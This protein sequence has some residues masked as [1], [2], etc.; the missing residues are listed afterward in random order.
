[1]DRQNGQIVGVAADDEF[2]VDDF[3]CRYPCVAAAGI[4]AARAR[5]SFCFNAAAR[6]RRSI[7]ACRCR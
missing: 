1:V 6:F 2:S 4:V 7:L 5:W 3:T